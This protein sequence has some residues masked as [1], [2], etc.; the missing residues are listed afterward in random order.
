MMRVLSSYGPERTPVVSDVHEKMS[1]IVA[2]D[3]PNKTYP[4][5][6]WCVEGG[7][8]RRRHALG[9]TVR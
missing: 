4:V 9:A 5:L 8:K 7:L 2:P 3:I 1:R 6:A